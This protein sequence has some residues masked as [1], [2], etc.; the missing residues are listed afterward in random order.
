[1]DFMV[2]IIQ[3]KPNKESEKGILNF[4]HIGNPKTLD[5]MWNARRGKTTSDLQKK[6][7][8]ERSKGKCMLKDPVSRISKQVIIGSVEDLNLRELGW[9]NPY[10][11]SLLEKRKQNETIVKD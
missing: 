1:M 8:R 7:L 9:M 3:R 2:N 10:K 4:T 5:A 11:L 6:V